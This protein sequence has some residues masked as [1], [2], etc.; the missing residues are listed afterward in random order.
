[1]R[2]MVLVKATKD[3]E[4]GVMP[5]TEL[6][7]RWASSTR[8][9]SRPASCWPARGCIRPRRAS[10][11]PSTARAAPSSTALP[12]TRELVAGFW[13]WQVKDMAEAVEWVKRCPNPMPGPSEIEIRPA[14][15][16]GW[17]RRGAAAASAYPTL[18]SIAVDDSSRCFFGVLPPG[19]ISRGEAEVLPRAG[20]SQVPPRRAPVAADCGARVGSM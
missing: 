1:M 6:L 2:V 9:W 5:S 19:M 7:A 4:A 15:R 13:L 11:S 16:G 3:S 17:L 20:S 8:N 10:G 14:V 18:I 12:E